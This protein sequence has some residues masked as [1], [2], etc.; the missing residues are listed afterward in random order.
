LLLDESTSA[1]DRQ[2]ER[3]I[4]QTLDK[5]STNR[6]TITIAHRLSTIINSDVIF[7]LDKG[8]IVEKGTHTELLALDGAYS[9]LVQ[10]QLS[11]IG[12]KNPA[13]PKKDSTN[14]N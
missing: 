8:F 7:V 10:N 13:A 5:F 12:V 11:S 14:G 3:S 9:K 2:N 4:Q 1:L 6:T